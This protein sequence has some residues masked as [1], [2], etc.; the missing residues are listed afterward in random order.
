MTEAKA[1]Q[2]V[3]LVAGVI[4]REETALVLAEAELER[5]FGPHDH[6]S[7][8]FVF[9]TTDYYEAEMGSNLKR[10]FL[11]FRRLVGPEKL[12]DIKLRTN[13]LEREIQVRLGAAGRPANIDPGILTASALIMATT[14]DFS[15]RVPLRDGVY[16]HL[17]LLFSKAGIRFLDWTYPDFKNKPGYG[18]FLLEVRRTYLAQLGELRRGGQA[19]SG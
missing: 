19:P 14:K 6:R 16:A 18:E 5:L 3:K 2:P 13:A 8:P 4:F 15:H 11:S 17:E 1:F 9:G 7:V 10:L 12:P